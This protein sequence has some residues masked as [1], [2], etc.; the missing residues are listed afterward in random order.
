LIV[1]SQIFEVKLLTVCG[2]LLSRRATIGGNV[3]RK[4]SSLFPPELSDVV[5]SAAGFSFFLSSSDAGRNDDGW[6]RSGT[7]LVRASV[8]ALPLSPA[9]FYARLRF[10]AETKS[11]TG[12][13][14][15]A[16]C[17]LI[18]SHSSLASRSALAKL[19][20]SCL[21]RRIESVV[22]LRDNRPRNGHHFRIEV[23]SGAARL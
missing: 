15:L 23:A 4:P 10:K 16:A 21:G 6:C 8:F 9:T 13:G 7:A 5:C 14:V 12:G 19:P 20:G 17:G 1:K 3:D 11:M 2:R 18:G 22:P